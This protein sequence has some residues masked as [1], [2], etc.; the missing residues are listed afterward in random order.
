MSS[1]TLSPQLSSWKSFPG[2]CSL[3]LLHP[4][5]G[6]SVWS[7]SIFLG[8]EESFFPTVLEL[9]TTSIGQTHPSP[10]ISGDRIAHIIGFTS[11]YTN[12]PLKRQQSKML[13]FP[14]SKNPNYFKRRNE[15][16]LGR[17]TWKTEI[18]SQASVARSQEQQKQKLGG[19]GQG[20][21]RHFRECTL[22]KEASEC[23]TLPKQKAAARL[24]C[25][26]SGL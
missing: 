13:A 8:A 20:G 14:P 3:Y 2:C 6:G 5:V 24:H 25:T 23:S 9:E 22:A 10:G 17:A 26:T 15:M 11:P 18:Q 4:V 1:K 19:Q 16:Q 21:I 7:Q 12:G